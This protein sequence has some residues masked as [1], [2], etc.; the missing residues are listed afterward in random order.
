MK[1]F[2]NNDNESNDS[3]EEIQFDILCRGISDEI[4]WQIVELL[5][6]AIWNR[7]C[8]DQVIQKIHSLIQ[9]GI[10]ID[11]TKLRELRLQFTGDTNIFRRP[12]LFVVSPVG[13]ADAHRGITKLEKIF[14][15]KAN[16]RNE[17]FG[18][19]A[20]RAQFR[21][22]SITKQSY[23]LLDVVKENYKLR[24]SLGSGAKFEDFIRNRILSDFD[25]SSF[26]FRRKLRDSQYSHKDYDYYE[27]FYTVRITARRRDRNKWINSEVCKKSVIG[28]SKAR[29][30]IMPAN[31]S[32]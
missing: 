27:S 14:K 10:S 4:S 3:F 12:E 18:M 13:F 15:L 31:P 20:P 17:K 8:V 28:T 19:P 2:R 24:Y 26:L 21:R 5:V 29:R 9:F 32:S 6:H 11:V 16:P 30:V 25:L 22:A 7:V 23:L 1:T